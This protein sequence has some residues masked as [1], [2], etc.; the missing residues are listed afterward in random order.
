[1]ITGEDIDKLAAL[2]RIELN[3]E[4]KSRF[5]KE[6]DSIL[7]YV[8]EIKEVT[9]SVKKEKVVLGVHNVFREDSGPHQSGIF[10]EVILSNM[11]EREGQYL[12]VKKIL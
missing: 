7:S 1:M 10:T 8:G 2:S 11:P 3:S 12:K 9:S 5:Q 6:I 4:E